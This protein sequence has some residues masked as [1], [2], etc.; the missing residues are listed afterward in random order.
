MYV[1]VTD[2][3]AEISSLMHTIIA[4]LTFILDFIGRIGYSEGPMRGHPRSFE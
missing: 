3:P 4:V 2:P 1:V